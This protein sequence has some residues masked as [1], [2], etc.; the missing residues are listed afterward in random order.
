MTVTKARHVR[1]IPWANLLSLSRLALAPVC[2]WAI[3]DASWLLAL[4]CLVVA[5]ATDFLDGPLA[6][7]RG[8]VTRLGG[9]LDHA[10]DATFVSVGLAALAVLGLVPWVLPFLV[11]LAFTQYTLDSRVLAGEFLR[12]S[13]LGRY[14]GIAYFVVLGIPIV[15]NSMSIPFPSD[16]LLRVFAWVVAVSTVI[17]M[18]DRLRAFFRSRNSS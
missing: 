16:T 15:R 14:N 18:A 13:L 7:R 2:A 12:A 8:E 10:S 9:V 11:V 6:R 1:G 17:S 5:V 4:V 3:V